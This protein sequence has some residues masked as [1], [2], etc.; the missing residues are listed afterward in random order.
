MLVVTRNCLTCCWILKN[1]ESIY[2]DK[3]SS[4]FAQLTTAQTSVKVQVA[5]YKWSFINKLQVTS[6]NIILNIHEFIDNGTFE[7]LF[8]DS[9]MLSYETFGLIG[10]FWRGLTRKNRVSYLFSYLLSIFRD[11]NNVYY[12]RF[13]GY[14]KLWIHFMVIYT[15][16]VYI[17]FHL[18]FFHPINLVQNPFFIAILVR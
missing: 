15:I 1:L 12:N 10:P 13:W 11:L 18:I 9:Q 7:L 3:R 5:Q 2:K 4:T 6:I 16:I 17:H 8:I 14:S